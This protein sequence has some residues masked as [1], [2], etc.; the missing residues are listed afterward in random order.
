[1]R[2]FAAG[3]KRIMNRKVRQV[4]FRNKVVFHMGNN[5]IGMTQLKDD[6]N[7]KALKRLRFTYVWND[8]TRP[9]FLMWH[10]SRVLLYRC[11]TVSVLLYHY[12]CQF[13]VSL[14][15]CISITVSVLL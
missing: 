15:Y 5:S 13:A 7:N 10:L 9:Q 6:V 3:P 4:D 14:L 12:Y 1:M 11:Y 2:N 8:E